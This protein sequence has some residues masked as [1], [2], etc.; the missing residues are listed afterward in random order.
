MGA[1]VDMDYANDGSNPHNVFL[2]PATS[3]SDALKNTFHY[4]TSS[5]GNFDYIKV[6]NN[7]DALEPVLLSASIDNHTFLFWNWYSEGHEW[8]CDGYLENTFTGCPGDPVLGQST[9]YFDMNWG[10]N[11]VGVSTNVNGWYG[12]SYWQVYNGS[13]LEYYQYNQEMTY[14]IHP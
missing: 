7:S 14:D 13:N 11:E 6:Q 10:W 5:E 2:N 9:L 4:T 8:V 3:C 1:C 12:F